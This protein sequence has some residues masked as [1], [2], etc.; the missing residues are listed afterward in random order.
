MA[1]V[2]LK[3]GGLIKTFIDRGWLPPECCRFILDVRLGGI[4]KL[5]AESY[6]PN[7]LQDVDL[8]SLLREPEK[9][10]APAGSDGG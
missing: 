4:V 2:P 8:A 5:Y 10:P 7:E 1:F 6:A 9:D 3:D